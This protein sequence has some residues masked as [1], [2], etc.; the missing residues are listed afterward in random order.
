MSLTVHNKDSNGSKRRVSYFYDGDVGLYYYG[1]GHPMKPHRLRMTHQLILTY[2]LY[3]KMEVYKPKPGSDYQMQRFHSEEYID[4]LKR[5]SPET[6]KQ[7]SHQ[8]QKFNVG[9]YTDCPVFDGLFE[10]CSMYTGC[11]LDG[12]VKL[13]HG[14]T[15]IAINW[16]GGLHHAK[17]ME[18]SGFC[19]V[20]DIVLAI[21]E[22]LKYHP[23]VLYVDIDIHH[24]DGVEEAFYTTD[25]VMTVS[26]HKYG[27]F[28]PGTGDIRDIGVKSGKYYAVN[29]PLQEGI[30]DASYETVFKPIMERVMDM[31]RPT[32]VVLQCGAD[33]LTG[34]R[35]GCFNLTLKG[36][37]ACVEYMKSFNIPL[38]V[39]GGGGYTV[40]NVARCWAY[41]T[42]VLLNMPIENEIPYNDFF[43]YYA[44]D[45]K[46]HLSPSPSMENLNKPEQLHAIT[47]RILQNLK[48]LQGVPSVQMHP[49]P[50]DWATT[51]VDDPQD[52]EDRFPDKSIVGMNADGGF[53]KQHDAEFY[54]NNKDQDAD[55]N[56]MVEQS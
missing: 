54:E 9:E 26:F 20:N 16:S 22:L 14:L 11:S 48:N 55:E 50:P 35:L 28:F 18:A 3:R 38:L 12:A 41:E 5:I 31:Y 10:F 39:L 2:G 44:P 53:K 4:F 32:A 42:S 17:K 27:D 21:L 29:I 56:M 51:G 15:D 25:R 30:D 34:D 7:F 13:N 37:A 1:P 19:Y 33:S 52:M 40:R 46:L 24:G 47:C 45:F 6:M 23:R 43:E 36:H 49:V 8:M